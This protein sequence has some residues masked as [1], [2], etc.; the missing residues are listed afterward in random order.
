M[1]SSRTNVARE[2][3]FRQLCERTLLRLRVRGSPE[4]LAERLLHEL[5]VTASVRVELRDDDRIHGI[6]G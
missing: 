3:A 2:R 5:V 4:D 6:Q 1:T